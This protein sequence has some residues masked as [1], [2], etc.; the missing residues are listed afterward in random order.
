[1]F[2][3]CIQTLATL[4]ALAGLSHAVAQTTFINE[5]HYDNA[6]GDVGEAVEIAGPA[7]TDLSGW[8]L[9][10][11]NGNGG[12]TYNT[13]SLSGIIPE[14]NNGY[15]TLSF[16]AV[17]LQNG[18]P[19]GLALV[20]SSATVIQFLSYEGTVIATNGPANGMTSSDIAVSE[21]S[22]SPEGQSLQLT[23]A[24]GT[25][26]AHFTWQAP[27][28]DS[29][30][31][32]NPGQ[33]F[34]G[35]SGPPAVAINELRIDQPSS[36]VDEYFELVG[37][38]GQSLDGLSY[39]VI[40]DGSGGSGVIESVSSL[41]GLA[42]PDSG[43]FLAAES[44]FTLETPD[45]IASLNFENSDNVTH[46]LVFEFTGSV[47]D[48]LDTNEDGV[49]DLTPWTSI[50]DSIALVE[51]ATSGEKVYGDASI[52]PDG[53]FVPGH[54][55][56]FP[57][58]TGPF[59]IGKF[60]LDEGND[61]PGGENIEPIVF[62]TSD[63]IFSSFE[64]PS[65]VDGSPAYS[66]PDNT[67]D[68]YLVNIDGVSDVA[69]DGGSEL[70]FKALYE[71]TRGDAGLSDGDF[72][73]VTKFTGV[74][75]AF[76][77]GV[78]AYQ[79]GDPDGRYTVEMDAVNLDNVTGE[80]TILVDLFVQ[81]TGWES[82][83]VI[84]VWVETDIGAFYLLDTTSTDIDS[85]NIEGFWQTLSADLTGASVAALRFS[86]DSNSA[87]ESIFVDNIRFGPAPTIDPYTIMEIQGSGSE[88][89]LVGQRLVTE[90]VVTGITSNGQNF[91]M[92]DPTGDGNAATSD[93]IYVYNPDSVP[94][95]GDLVR[96]TASVS[97]YAS[98]S[99]PT[100]L[101][102]T[103]LVAGTVEVLSSNNPLPA[104]VL[105]TDMPD[106]SIPEA[107]ALLE[108]LESMLVKLPTALVVGQTN[109]FG[110]FHVITSYDAQ[111]GS[112]FSPWYSQM[113]IR[114]IGENEV[115]YNP[116]RLLVDD[117]TLD[118]PLT[119][120]PGDS[121]TNL[122]GIMHYDF[123]NYR[124]QP[125]D[126]GDVSIE[127]TATTIKPY[128]WWFSYLKS[129]FQRSYLNVASLNTENLFDLI[130]DPDKND[131]GSTPTPE[132]LEIKLEKLSATIGIGLEFP[133]IICVQEVENQAVLQLL[134]DRLNDKLPFA[135]LDYLAVSLETSD[136]RGIE[137]GYLYDSRRVKLE[138]LYQLT[139]E[140]VPGVSDAFGATSV[141]KGREPL[142]GVF[143]S[144]GREITIVNNH[145]KSKGGDG[146][147]YGTE[148]PPV[149]ESE[150]QRKLQAT[151]LRD[152]ADILLAENPNALLAITG[153]FNDFQ[154]GEPGEGDSH[155]LGIIEGEEG[156]YPLENIVKTRIPE[157]SRFSYVYEG[158]S[159]ALDHF[160]LSKKL[161]KKL[162][163]AEF[164]HLNAA[165]LDEF[166]EDAS[167]LERSS[168]HDP[169]L[170][171]FNLTRKGRSF[172]H[173]R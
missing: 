148:Q 145:F 160:L 23:G 155:T 76:T 137:T 163:R 146:P 16:P 63:S 43:Y 113:I 144:K 103:E 2:K 77:D 53:T 117:L 135:R 61:T 86:L 50:L 26:Y 70:G 28:D 17:G 5:I 164:I 121:L 62:E 123:S 10:L 150:I 22:S 83:D 140:I 13:L 96:V 37:L 141:S 45:M 79:I 58:I 136:N 65:V 119:L 171:K 81:S 18:S 162:L 52:G 12:A 100:D 64:E 11:Y 106:E 167:V 97:E 138:D 36:D 39:L 21:P 59:K 14:Q 91:W 159:Q 55:Y 133:E 105:I 111:P 19:D 29:F 149:R 142:V 99:R 51:S 73:G 3:N 158:N 71:N 67:T 109:Q 127:Q 165:Y 25:E 166:M 156:E 54:V 31:S 88:S 9:A 30:G 35:V 75:G 1:M 101:P 60:D 116:E 129:L 131:Q 87:S 120:M 82:N 98:S 66:D 134:A 8:S 126:I 89:P 38:P 27:D 80:K 93:G 90:G 110:E 72:V 132:E 84:Q 49:L 56:R 69:Y 107:I 112:G 151:V 108:S 40:G 169:L 46:L 44:S 95:I 147:L 128:Y 172:F 130:D 57:D 34:A 78:Q 139:D 161:K 4:S 168:D 102:L 74:V 104:P 20:D 33:T 48:D 32:V 42:I 125:V 124:I 154:F 143:K 115:D 153:D 114:S 85:L 41:D 6:S 118:E 157:N 122:T 173:H 92:Q 7:G 170:L 15:G 24:N 152:F 47:G 94:A 68:H